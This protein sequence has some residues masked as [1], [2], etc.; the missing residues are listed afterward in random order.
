[1]S[2][3]TEKRPTLSQPLP[4]P[5]AD[6]DVFSKGPNAILFAFYQLFKTAQMHAIDNQA[7][8]RPIQTMFEL[9]SAIFKRDGRVSLQMG[10]RVLFLNGVRLKL[11]TEEY[12]FANRVFE[13]FRERGMAGFDIDAALTPDSIRKVLQ[14]LVYAAPPERTFEKI[15]AALKAAQLGFNVIKAGEA[16]TPIH[17]EITDRRELTFY[18]YSKLLVLYR[19]L[20]NEEKI[21]G[22]NRQKFVRKIVRSIQALVD[23]AVVED[24]LLVAA[25]SVKD[26]ENYAPHH[27]SNVALLSIALGRK[28]GVGKIDLADLG[29][30]AV[31]HDI[32]LRTCPAELLE[33]GGALD[34]SERAVINQHPIRSVEF[35]LGERRFTKSALSRIV[36][37][38]EHHRTPSGTGYPPGSRKPDLFSRIVSIADVYD[39]LTTRRP[40]RK[41]FRP[42]VAL[43]MMLRDSGQRFDP[44]LLSAFVNLIGLYPVGTLVRLDTGEMGVVVRGGGEGKRVSRPVVLLLDEKH[45][46]TQTVDLLE[47]MPDGAYRRTIVGSEDP[48]I[49]GIQTSGFLARAVIF[50]A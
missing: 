14:I 8:L 5:I 50:A 24:E 16:A 29:V 40:W 35:L 30:A 41:A 48:L 15:D 38:F 19:A 46:R 25:A 4:L 43:G 12:E 18:T 36:V 32:G 33:K 37:A 26:A 31:F 27:A 11:S 10:D 3:P 1:L 39:A 13:L 47:E 28:V 17:E 7:L 9:S 20:M 44:S 49:Y 42:D 2:D 34:S 22:A 6:A 21:N 23:I 45:Q